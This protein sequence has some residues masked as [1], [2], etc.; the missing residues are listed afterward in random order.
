MKSVAIVVYAESCL[1]TGF[2]HAASNAAFGPG[3]GLIFLDNVECEGTEDSLLDCRGQDAGNHNCGRFEDAG[4][5]CPGRSSSLQSVC[6][7]M[8]I[9]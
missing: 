1:N 9:W 6:V 2:A 5:Y 3:S 7:D 8:C 4:V